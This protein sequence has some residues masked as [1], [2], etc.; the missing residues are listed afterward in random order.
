MDQL[1]PSDLMPQTISETT[2]ELSLLVNHLT[3]ELPFLDSPLQLDKSR[4][5]ELSSQ[6]HTDTW[7][8][9]LTLNQHHSTLPL[10]SKS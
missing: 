10:I 4:T 9:V 3:L 7:S 2:Q 5:S 1:M 8:T 6:L